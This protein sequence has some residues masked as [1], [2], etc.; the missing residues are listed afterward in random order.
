MREHSMSLG[1]WKEIVKFKRNELKS[2]FQGVRM[3]CP[4]HFYLSS[5]QGHAVMMIPCSRNHGIKK[6]ES[7]KDNKKRREGESES[8]VNLIGARWRAR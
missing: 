4:V 5:R 3:L 6:S 7:E 2:E 8:E 1:R